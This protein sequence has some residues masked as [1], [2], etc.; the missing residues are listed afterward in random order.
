MRH[1]GFSVIALLLLTSL[2]L[3]ACGGGT[4]QAPTAAGP[5]TAPTAAA[6][7]TAAEAPTTAATPGGLSPEIADLKA[8]A[9]TISQEL[10]DALDGKFKGT[11]VTLTGP[12]VAEDANRYND[13][14]KDFEDATGIDVQFEGTKEFE[15][16]IAAR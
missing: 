11:K 10:V 16:T 5:A 8:K 15:A 2:I 7:P 13:T 3:A 14:F 9:A 1:K 12:Q 6:V 4:T